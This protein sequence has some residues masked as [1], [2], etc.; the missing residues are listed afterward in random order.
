MFLD[1]QNCNTVRKRAIHYIETLNAKELPLNYAKDRFSEITGLWDRTTLKAYFGTHAHISKKVYRR[2]AR[3]QTGTYSM[4]D[5]VLIRKTETTKGYLEKLG[6]VHF[7]QRGKHWFMVI[8]QS[9]VP[10]PQLVR[11]VHSPSESSLSPPIC[12]TDDFSQGERVR[13]NRFEKVVS[14]NNLQDEREKT[15]GC[16]QTDGL[17]TSELTSS[18]KA[19]LGSA[20]KDG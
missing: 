2:E 11:K 16:K 15:G 6:L 12:S 8:H 9:A 3:Y 17:I 14:V 5:L 7:E 19:I 13:E 10:T 4:K 1:M 18:E 20:S